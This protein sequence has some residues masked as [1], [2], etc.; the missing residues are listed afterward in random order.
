MEQSA[1]PAQQAMQINNFDEFKQAISQSSLSKYKMSDSL[2]NTIVD[3]VA[4]SLDE[5][6]N[7]EEAFR[8]NLRIVVDPNSGPGPRYYGQFDGV[9]KGDPE[10]ADMMRWQKTLREAKALYKKLGDEQFDIA[11]EPTKKLSPDFDH[12]DDGKTTRALVDGKVIGE[13]VSRKGNAIP[14]ASGLE[15]LGIKHDGE[16]RRIVGIEVYGKGNRRQGV[17][18]NLYLRHFAQHPD[19]WFYN[20][21]A[22]KDAGLTLKSLEEQGLIEIVWDQIDEGRR[23]KGYTDSFGTRAIRITPAGLEKVRGMDAEAAANAAR[24]GIFKDKLPEGFYVKSAAVVGSAK[25]EVATAEQWKGMLKKGD[26][27]TEEMDDLGLNEFFKSN[28]KPTR[29]QVLDHIEANTPKI[30]L[31]DGDTGYS[32]WQIPGGDP[33]T[34]QEILIKMPA[35]SSLSSAQQSALDALNAKL[36][37][38]IPLNR[39]ESMMLRELE[40]TKNTANYIGPHYQDPNIVA[41]MRVDTITLPNGKKSLRIQEVQSDWHQKAL[42]LRNEELSKVSGIQYRLNDQTINPAFKEWVKANKSLIDSEYPISRYYQRGEGKETIARRKIEERMDS[43]RDEMETLRSEQGFDKERFT[44]LRSE[45]RRLKDEYDEIPFSRS[46]VVPDAPFKKSWHM[47]ALKQILRKAAEDGFDEVSIV[48]GSDIAKAVHGP[49]D[50]LESFYDIISSDLKKYT[51]R[52]GS[53]E[54]ESNFPQ[55]QLK[56]QKLRWDQVVRARLWRAQLEDGRTANVILDRSRGFVA[57]IE[58]VSVG[59]FE[60]SQEARDAITKIAGDRFTG[61]VKVFKITDKMRQDLLGEGQPLYDI[62]DEAAQKSLRE[63]AT[64]AAKGLAQSARRT[65]NEIFDQFSEIYKQ[66]PAAAIAAG[67]DTVGEAVANSAPVRVMRGIFVPE[68]M[69]ATNVFAQEVGRQHYEAI[70]RTKYLT[71][72]RMFPVIKKLGEFEQLNLDKMKKKLGAGKE[73]EATARVMDNQMAIRNYLEDASPLLNKG[74]KFTLPEE[75]KPIQKELDEMRSYI[76]ELAAIQRESG[77]KVGELQ[78]SFISYFPRTKQG[79]PREALN[80]LNN[81]GRQLD[82]GNR[83]QLSRKEFLKDIPG[84]TTT[85]NKIAMDETFSGIAHQYPN[86]VVPQD[87]REELKKRL[88]NEYGGGEAATKRK[89]NLFMLEDPTN[90]L[91]KFVDWVVNL[92]TR[93]AA[94]Q[95]PVFRLDVTTDLLNYAEATMVAAGAGNFATSLLA[96]GAR[97]ATAGGVSVEKVV[98]TLAREGMDG[99]QLDKI[100][101]AKMGDVYTSKYNELQEK[102]TEVVRSEMERLAQ[103]GDGEIAVMWS[104][105][106]DAPKVRIKDG[107]SA[108]A[109]GRLAGINPDG[110]YKFQ[111]MIER[112]EEV[113]EAGELVER[114]FRDVDE[115]TVRLDEVEANINPRDV[116]R[117]FSVDENVDAVFGRYMKGHTNP[118][119][120]N[121]FFGFARSLTNLYKSGLTVVWPA[122]H[123]RNFTSAMYNNWLAGASDPRYTGPRA[124]AQ[125]VKDADALIRG[126]K[127][128]GLLEIPVIKD[129]GIRT[130]DEAL[131]FIKREIFANNLYGPTQGMPG[132]VVGQELGG[133]LDAIP[134]QERSLRDVF[135]RIPGPPPGAS[136]TDAFNPLGAAGVLG[137]ADTF[138]PYRWGRQVGQHVEGLVRV[139]PFLAFLRQGMDVQEAA[140]RVMEVQFDY[141]K[142]TPTERYAKLLVPF[143]S[144]TRNNIPFVAKNLIENPGGKMGQT[145]RAVTSAQTDEPLP[146]FI[147]GTAAVPYPLSGRGSGADGTRSYIT[148]LGLGFEDATAFGTILGGNF[149]DAF[150]QGL[151][152]MNPVVKGPLEAAF[153]ESTYFDGPG[154]GRSLTD[155]DSSLG[156]VRDNIYDL[157]TGNETKGR[158]APLFGSETL[159]QLSAN[160][161]TSRLVTTARTLTD[162]RKLTRP[163][164]MLLNL[165]TGI[166]ISDVSPESWDAAVQSKAMERLREMGA[167]DFVRSY[168]PE[169]QKERLT[170]EELTETEEIQAILTWLATRSKDRKALEE[171]REILKDSIPKEQ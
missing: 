151:S 165:L 78:D 62:A 99:R 9:V 55:A 106:K 30:E 42:D 102:Y 15:L 96:K 69:G 20:T 27:K 19:A 146:D 154:G 73:T 140:R 14:E 120:M 34:Y 82:P 170:D 131:D 75:L 31:V 60:T 37:E 162:K 57:E 125:T 71:R 83:H 41:H 166:K 168:I 129:A 116:F 50:K 6:D 87:V 17:G 149:S 16:V 161:P 108:G 85:I 86:K 142:L 47:L 128:E 53:F 97:P 2:L 21:Q 153:G 40:R 150:R 112:T 164:K 160:L 65:G 68:V 1:R 95:I 115:L 90:Q 122:F 171:E 8:S 134:G 147:A 135:L 52:W 145:I 79:L 13:I 141:S 11:D 130:E 26:V 29:Q 92:D 36:D 5:F 111:Q 152:R 67:M 22:S 35:K 43:I 148:G 132:D 117:E 133:I 94:M 118:E 10:Y 77:I 91:D 28:P 80:S 101:S 143:Y 46:N 59:S 81:L 32:G 126:K 110:T 159:E 18:S 64:D 7:F 44:E 61:D 137:D 23:A 123:V 156:R 121:E 107:E 127:I 51:K 56:P 139:A 38:G 76:N 39:G 24:K 4:D 93:H 157:A 113:E 12:V 3:D 74:E 58:G 45:L 104:S 33:G 98:E 155:L 100:V 163:D 136:K 158:A 119:A 124:Y 89:D 54:G 72:Q 109:V 70:E 63:R 66:S 103:F 114:T 167:R 48:K 25:Q 144:Y 88:V 138:G 49:E 105:G 169:Y 84:G